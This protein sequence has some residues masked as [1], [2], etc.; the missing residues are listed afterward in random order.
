[1]GKFLD[2]ITKNME[3][4]ERRRE[5]VENYILSQF[6]ADDLEEA[7]SS[8]GVVDDTAAVSLLA[9]ANTRWLESLEKNPELGEKY[10]I[11][12]EDPRCLAEV[13]NYL[14]HCEEDT[15]PIGAYNFQ[16][17]SGLGKNIIIYGNAL[18]EMKSK[19]VEPFE[20]D[21][22]EVEFVKQSVL[23]G[24]KKVSGHGDAL[25]QARVHWNDSKYIITNF[26][27]DTNSRKTAIMSLLSLHLL[28]KEGFDLSHLLPAA[29][30]EEPSYKI[31]L[32]EHIPKGV[33]HS[34]LRG[35]EIKKEEGFTNVGIRV[36]RTEDV[37]RVMDDFWNVYQKEG[38]YASLNPNGN[39]EFALDHIDARFM[40]EGSARIAPISSELELCP[41]KRLTK[42]P[43]YLESMKRL[44]ARDY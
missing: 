28:E 9:G 32:D 35:D 29:Y 23:D 42:I 13:K 44:L 30:I 24:K 8:S 25:R 10:N 41:A 7:L 43:N 4:T 12:A 6:D 38:S 31:V 16:A 20:S 27:N 5:K 14:P 19:I 26:G 15:L 21:S 39:D 11:T 33:R 1:M 36:Y 18:E 2:L 17:V 3:N 34:K 22:S 40:S 37:K